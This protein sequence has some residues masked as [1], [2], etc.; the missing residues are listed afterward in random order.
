MP[1]KLRTKT[2]GV[3]HRCNQLAYRVHHDLK[4]QD[5]YC[6]IFVHI[7]IMLSCN[8]GRVSASLGSSNFQLI[9]LL[10]FGEY[11]NL[12]LSGLE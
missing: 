1:T 12:L 2:K 5:T 3:G 8:N 10:G 4:S 6:V 11:S 9:K 7:S